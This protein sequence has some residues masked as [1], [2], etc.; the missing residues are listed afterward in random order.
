MKAYV[1]HLS[2]Q[3]PHQPRN[4]AFTLELAREAA[5]HSKIA[6]G[7]T[8]LMAENLEDFRKVVAENP[9]AA[10]MLE[11]QDLASIFEVKQDREDRFKGLEVGDVVVV[12]IPGGK[13]M[14]RG[15]LAIG[16]VKRTLHHGPY[17]VKQ[18]DDHCQMQVELD[19]SYLPG[20]S[21]RFING[22]PCC[23]SLLGDLGIVARSTITPLTD[24][25]LNRILEAIS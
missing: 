25:Q 21:P 18:G 14:G 13:E 10:K 22:N 23:E 20:W 7:G 24:A 3:W 2:Y 12:N 4:E 8:N 11:G 1:V 5:R 17:L 9:E 6:I 16:K 19:Y 15:V